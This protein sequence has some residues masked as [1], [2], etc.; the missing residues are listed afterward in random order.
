M[1]ENGRSCFLGKHNP[2]ALCTLG[3]GIAVLPISAPQALHSAG[4]R[5]PLIDVD[6]RNP[7]KQLMSLAEMMIK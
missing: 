7:V 3:F 4:T 1:D 2:E 6:P 5:R